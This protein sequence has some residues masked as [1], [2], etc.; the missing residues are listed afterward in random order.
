MEKVE[1]KAHVF[2]VAN[3]VI[4]VSNAQ[5]K[6]NE[7]LLYETSSII[8]HI[9]SDKNS[10]VFKYKILFFSCLNLFYFEFTVAN[11]LKIRKRE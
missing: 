7:N 8:I 3:D 2:K 6:K 1:K 9:K 11:Q 10:M 4:K 5:K